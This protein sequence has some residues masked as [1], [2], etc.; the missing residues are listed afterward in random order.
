[1]AVAS[2]ATSAKTQ[3]RQIRRNIVKRSS[4]NGIKRVQASIRLG[5]RAQ[6][7]RATAARIGKINQ[8]YRYDSQS[9]SEKAWRNQQKATT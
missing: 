8:A 5:N 7:Q 4:E 6:P 1:M 3:Y 9:N 2:M